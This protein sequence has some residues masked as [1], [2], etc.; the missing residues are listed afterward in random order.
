MAGQYAKPRSADTEVVDGERIPTFK[1][2]CVNDFDKNNRSPDPDRLLQS[3]FYSSA[4]LNHIRTLLE[5]G[6]ADLHESKHWQ[7]DY[8]MCQKRRQELSEMVDNLLTSLQFMD[9]C[10][11]S[12][13]DAVRTVDFFT[14]HEGLILPY[15]SALT[16]QHKDGLYYDL[17]AHMLWIGDRTRQ[18]DHAHIEFFRG[19]EN[20]VGVKVGPSSTPEGV[21][22]MCKVLDPQNRPGKLVLITRMGSDKVKSHLPPIVKAVTAHGL[23][24]VWQCDPMHG[25]TE[26]TSTGLKT[27]P[28]DRVLTELM[29]TCDVHTECGSVLG[30][31]HFELTGEDVTEC[32]GGPQELG[33]KDLHV[34][35]TTYCDPRLN[36]AQSMEMAFRIAQALRGPRDPSDSPRNGLTNMQWK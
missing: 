19:V 15:E 27:R 28:F 24:V 11:V 4:T 29:H 9:M 31:V 35:Y 33:E 3:Y 17:S 6:F 12:Q 16:K 8:V 1:G 10:G 18:L 2:D 36:Y 7:L 13:N 22:E 14:S 25:N 30:G 20:P 26:S 34:R 5:S 32:V 23:H 21:V